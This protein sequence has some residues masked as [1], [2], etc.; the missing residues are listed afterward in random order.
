MA[1]LRVESN[2]DGSFLLID[3]A[4]RRGYY[5][6][7]LRCRALQ[8]AVEFYGEDVRPVGDLFSELAADWR[9]WEGERAWNSL[10]GEVKLRA[11]HDKL[12]TA[13]LTVELRSDV[14]VDAGYLWTATG[15]LFLDAGAL[16]GLARQAGQL[17][18]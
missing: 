9:G 12:G 18:A 2:Q 6:A 7:E 17:P 1:A 5:Q 14:Y 8:A 16:D 11:T 10:E 15:L 3:R 13:A 4:S